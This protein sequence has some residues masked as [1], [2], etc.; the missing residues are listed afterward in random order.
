M[1][2][3]THEDIGV[4]A[5]NPT[6]EVIGSARSMRHLKPTPVPMELLRTLV[7]AGTRAPNPLNAQPW[8]FLIVTDR[9]IIST[10]GEAVASALAARAASRPSGRANSRSGAHLSQTLATV[11]A[12]IVV[13]AE[14]SYPPEKPDEF[15]AWACVFP[16]SQNI[17]LAA[18][19]LGLG[20]AFTTYHHFAPE[21][22]ARELAI[23]SHVHIGTVIPVGWPD[24]PFGPVR[25]RP[26]ED[27]IHYDRWAPQR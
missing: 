1:A 6:L 11:P 5:N 26:I 18:R 9:A 17:L 19:A 10:L 2:T 15:Y 13:G 20:A 21:V 24:R 7:W 14:L 8:H 23:P 16:A 3:V 27:V 25:R 4:H 12:L 22:F